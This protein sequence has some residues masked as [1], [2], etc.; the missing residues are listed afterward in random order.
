MV[1]LERDLLASAITAT[2]VKMSRLQA[3]HSAD[4]VI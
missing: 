3:D 2:A 4:Q 1:Q